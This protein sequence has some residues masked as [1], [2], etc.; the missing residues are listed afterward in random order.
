MTRKTPKIYPTLSAR[1]IACLALIQGE[2]GQSGCE[3][4]FEAEAKLAIISGDQTRFD[5]EGSD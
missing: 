1:S 4:G 2:F 3:S 5:E